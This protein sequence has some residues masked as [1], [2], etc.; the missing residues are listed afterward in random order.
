MKNLS[1]TILVAGTVLGLLLFFTVN[2][3]DKNLRKSL[4]VG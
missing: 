2:Q 3:A 4:N 1:I